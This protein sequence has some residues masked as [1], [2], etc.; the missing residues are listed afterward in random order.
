[1]KTIIIKR[2]YKT[3]FTLIFL[4][5]LFLTVRFSFI[6]NLEEIDSQ[7]QTI[8]E[9]YTDSS[10]NS[11]DYSKID[12]LTPPYYDKIFRLAENYGFTI[13]L[14]SIVIFFILLNKPK[15]KKSKFYLLLT[16]IMIDWIIFAS[17][18]STIRLSANEDDK[19]FIS[20]L[21]FLPFLFYICKESII[22]KTID[23][24]A[25]V[26]NEIETKHE[27]SI[28][29]LKK[30]LEMELI[31][32]EEYNE[33]IEFRTKEKIRTEIKDTEE[34]NLLLKSKQKGLLSEEEF[35]TKVE[36]LVSKKSQAK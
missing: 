26:K 25:E 21:I 10:N 32:Q 33:K 7:V 35:N 19:Y 36:N 1:M 31:S 34:F 14:F 8:Y 6:K 11:F 9:K 27:D 23:I 17:T 29:D 28:S 18:T 24:T 22:G 15:Y 3:L 12:K 2:D 30:L 13:V 4:I 16:I 5:L 20:L